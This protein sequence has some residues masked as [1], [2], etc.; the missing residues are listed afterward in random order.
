MLRL[1]SAGLCRAGYPNTSLTNDRVDL[2]KSQYFDT[3][4]HN[5]Q[6]NRL[7]TA[8]EGDH[9]GRLRRIQLSPN[10]LYAH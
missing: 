3:L 8:I 10:N 4:R 6:T 7:L 9:Y 2:I 5:Q 1:T